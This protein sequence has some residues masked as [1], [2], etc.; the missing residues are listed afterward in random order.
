MSP[1]GGIFFNNLS[2]RVRDFWRASG[3]SDGIFHLEIRYHSYNA[4]AKLFKMTLCTVN[5]DSKC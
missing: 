3:V 4:T 1:W 2:K 5:V